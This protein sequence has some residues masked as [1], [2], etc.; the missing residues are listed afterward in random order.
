MGIKVGDLVHLFRRRNP[1][2]ALV[3]GH[4]PDIIEKVACP[5]AFFQFLKKWSS[6][7]PGARG[8]KTKWLSYDRILIDSGLRHDVLDSF[9]LYNRFHGT[10]LS[11]HRHMKIPSGLIREFIY[12]RWVKPSSNYT[13]NR[14]RDR[15]G[16][17]PADWFKKLQ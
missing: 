10:F 15:T 17:Y 3:L 13:I 12:V 9:M 8:Q 4:I 2:I 5:E 6:T 16:W 1:G 7:K 11:S 14:I